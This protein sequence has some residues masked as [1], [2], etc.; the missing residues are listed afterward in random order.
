MHAGVISVALY[1]SI[2]ALVTALLL[3]TKTGHLVS[4]VSGKLVN[5]YNLSISASADIHLH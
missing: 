5:G 3:V 2:A 4:P 1:W